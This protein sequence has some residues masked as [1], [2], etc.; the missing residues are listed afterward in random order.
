VDAVAKEGAG[1]YDVQ[2][3]AARA[4]VDTKECASMRDVER[5]LLFLN[6]ERAELSDRIEQQVKDGP[7]TGS[8]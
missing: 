1:A 5:R 2:Q 3:Q 7:A 8:A 6:F 4:G